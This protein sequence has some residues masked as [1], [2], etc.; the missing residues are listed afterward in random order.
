MLKNSRAALSNMALTSHK[1]LFKFKFT[2]IKKN[3]KCSFSVP[4]VTLQVY[5]C[6]MW[7]VATVLVQI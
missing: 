7:L 6:H 3:V 1:R 5:N 4:L 2:K